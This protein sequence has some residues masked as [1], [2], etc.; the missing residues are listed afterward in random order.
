MSGSGGGGSGGGGGTYDDAP[1]DRLRF[2]AQITSPQAPVVATI[3]VG[4]VLDVV[5]A[6]MHGVLV[7]QVLKNGQVAGG[8]AGPDA[9]RLRNCIDKGFVYRAVVLAVLGGQ[10]R[11]RVEPA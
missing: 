4:D 10:V 8:L 3:S 7:V 2:D 9:S 5:V 6:T 11:V 1:C